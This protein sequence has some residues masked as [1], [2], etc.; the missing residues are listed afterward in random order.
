MELVHP[1][2]ESVSYGPVLE[3]QGRCLAGMEGGGHERGLSKHR[4][5]EVICL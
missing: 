5:G 2:P 3:A 1:E 4:E